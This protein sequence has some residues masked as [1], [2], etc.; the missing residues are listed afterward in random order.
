MNKAIKTSVAAFAALAVLA[1]CSPSGGT[2]A[3]VNGEKIA[4]S[5]VVAATNACIASIADVGGAITGSDVGVFRSSVVT[6][7]VVSE[8]ARQF[9]EKSGAEEPEEADLLAI[10]EQG[11]I[12]VQAYTQNETCK[13]L[14]VGLGLHSYYA[15]TK[16]VQYFNNVEVTVNPRYGQFDVETLQLAGTGALAVMSQG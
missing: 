5:Q 6:L 14:M 7:S 12:P 9:T 10:L 4:D 8:L 13:Q 2:A 15:T 11:G 3:I 1:G 16:R